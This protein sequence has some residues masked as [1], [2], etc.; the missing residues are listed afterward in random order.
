MNLWIIDPAN[1]YIE[2]LGWTLLHFVW[3]GLAIAILF[4]AVRHFSRRLSADARYLTGCAAMLLL[5]VTPLVTFVVLSRDAGSLET[6]AVI[7]E[8]PLPRMS[9]APVEI[10]SAPA[11]RESEDGRAFAGSFVMFVDISEQRRVPGASGLPAARVP[12]RRVV[13]PRTRSHWLGG[14]FWAKKSLTRPA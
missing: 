1:P 12:N 5:L 4:A 8:A 2:A 10:V 13:I 7:A 3:Q 11:E 9:E 14:K 6:A